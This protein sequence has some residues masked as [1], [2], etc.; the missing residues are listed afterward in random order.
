MFVSFFGWLKHSSDIF[1][2][3]E[4]VPLGDSEMNMKAHLGRIPDM[5]ARDITEQILSGLESIHAE[6]FAR[7]DLKPQVTG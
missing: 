2:A 5:K 4:Y 3:M 6:S 7:R 1:L